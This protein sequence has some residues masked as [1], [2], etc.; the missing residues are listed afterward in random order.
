MMPVQEAEDL[1]GVELQRGDSGV[2]QTRPSG[3]SGF[4][5]RYAM[6]SVPVRLRA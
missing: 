6:A 5:M 3:K 2:M 1:L 4:R